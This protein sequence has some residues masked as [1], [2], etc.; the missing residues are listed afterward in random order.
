M[1][2]KIAALLFFSFFFFFLPFSMK[3]SSHSFKWNPPY[4][5]TGDC[6]VW[7][8]I[9]KLSPMLTPCWKATKRDKMAYGKD[10][11]LQMSLLSGF[12]K[13]IYVT[14]LLF[15]KVHEILLQEK[16]CLFRSSQSAVFFRVHHLETCLDCYIVTICLTERTLHWQY[17]T[18]CLETESVINPA[19]PPFRWFNSRHSTCHSSWQAVYLENRYPASVKHCMHFRSRQLTQPICT[20][21]QKD[22]M[23]ILLLY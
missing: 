9:A 6:L 18:Y 16:Y 8:L 12:E 23:L 13:T 11:T 2:K 3:W 17:A 19:L 15:W 4:G 1:K 22:T 21:I 10:L 14:L 5:Y 20:K 7:W